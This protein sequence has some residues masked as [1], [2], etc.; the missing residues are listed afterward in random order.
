MQYNRFLEKDI[1]TLRKEA[2][3]LQDM[4]EKDQPLRNAAELYIYNNDLAQEIETFSTRI[5]EQACRIET[6]LDD[7]PSCSN[8]EEIALYL[9]STAQA[10][11]AEVQSIQNILDA[12]QQALRTQSTAGGSQ[13]GV[14]QNAISWV[15][16]YVV[17]ILKKIMANVWQ[18]LSGLLTPKGWKVKGGIGTSFLGLANAELEITFGPRYAH[19]QANAAD[20]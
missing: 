18:I 13:A 8:R 17:P 16:Q 1:E 19:N 15:K 2:N 12:K 11:D 9:V 3:R 6:I 10:L 5:K 4:T 20:R 7:L 14:I